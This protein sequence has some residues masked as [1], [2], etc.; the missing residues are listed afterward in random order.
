[1]DTLYT[2][3]V[4]SFGSMQNAAALQKRLGKNFKDVTIAP[5]TVANQTFYR[6][7]IGTF[8]NKEL[9]TNFGTDSLSRSGLS[10]RIVE[11]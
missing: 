11:K 7:R 8:K 10:Y 5:I 9:A 3:Q 4:G 1:L 6:V 2:L